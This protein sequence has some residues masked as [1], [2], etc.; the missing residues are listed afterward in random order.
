MRPPLVTL[1]LSCHSI[2]TGHTGDFNL[3]GYPDILLTYHD[4]DHARVAL[5]QNAPQPS[6]GLSLASRTF[7]KVDADDMDLLTDVV[8]AAFVD[9]TENVRSP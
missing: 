9:L 4:H 3:D 7:V 8:A 5:L 6:S 2:T 1:H